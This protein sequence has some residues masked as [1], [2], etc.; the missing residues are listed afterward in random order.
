MNKFLRRDGSPQALKS[1]RP[2]P[3][4]VKLL[5]SESDLKSNLK[6]AAQR[7]RPHPQRGLIALLSGLAMGCTVAPINAW[8]LA[9]VAL[10]P[11]WVMIRDQGLGVRGL[12]SGVWGLGVG[13]VGVIEPGAAAETAC[14]SPGDPTPTPPHSPTPPLLLPL[15][16]GIGYHGLALSWMVD[17]HPLTWMGI[18]WLG[19]VAIAL[20]AWGFITL[21]GAAIALTWSLCLSLTTRWLP[22]S[23]PLSLSL[24]LLLINTTLWCAIEALWSR[25]PLF[26]TSLAF[27]QSPFNLPILHLGQL[28]GPTAVTAAI[29]AVNGLLAE[30]FLAWRDRRPIAAAR[31][32]SRLRVGRLIALALALLIAV[33]LAGWALWQQPLADRPDQA[34]TVGLVQGNVPT[35]IKLF[36][37]G[38]RLALENYTQ[39]YNTLADAGV[40]LVVMPEGAFPWLWVGTAQQA[41]HPLYQAVLARGVPV[42][43]G[44]I[45]QQDGHITQ[46][47]FALAPALPSNLAPALP[48][49]LTPSGDITGRYDK[50][51]LVPLGEYIPFEDLLGRVIGRLSPMAFSMRPG[52]LEQQFDTPVGRAIAA[53]CYESAFSEVFRRQAAAGGEFI[54]TASNNDP[55]TRR[56]MAQHHAQ[57]V[58]RAIEGDRWAVRVTNTGLSG[59]VSPHG[60]TAWLSGYRTLET[61]SATVYR[62]Q[63]QTPYVRWGDWLLWLLLGLSAIALIASWLRRSQNHPQS[64]PF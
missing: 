4:L 37:T 61:H 19:S 10:A 52:T 24:P 14:G 13:N 31:L 46:S 36:E 53:I 22:S 44:T 8:W 17:L 58:M 3:T 48:S 42:V 40:D 20:F 16:W 30:G 35:R 2:T 26:W 1:Y 9:W 29:V 11:L 57:D 51:K 23:L 59:I 47:L 41:R 54:L 60:E 49:N 63:R 50:A 43:V 12:G 18:P 55:Y 27:T 62:R 5:G 33:H 39:G 56:M 32:D 15:L 38:E 34:F 7:L 6:N 21:W 45:G 25:S 28:S 64:P